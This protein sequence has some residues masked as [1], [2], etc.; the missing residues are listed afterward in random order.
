MRVG[1]QYVP[2]TT[3]LQPWEFSSDRSAAINW[4]SKK[5]AVQAL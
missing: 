5:L 1:S 4:L 2:A 3:R